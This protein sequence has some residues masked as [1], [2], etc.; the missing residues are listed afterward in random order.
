MYTVL[1]VLFWNRNQS[2][3][4]GTR[5]QRCS[6]TKGITRWWQDGAGVEEPGSG[7]PGPPASSEEAS[8]WESGLRGMDPGGFHN[9]PTA[10]WR[11][12]RLH[13]RQLHYHHCYVGELVQRILIYLFFCFMF[14]FCHIWSHSSLK[15]LLIQYIP[16]QLLNI[17]KK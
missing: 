8:G 14:T 7:S 6:R 2:L 12:H 11:L 1:T 3:F 5:R 15:I 9:R 17:L 10:V 16:C 4:S 13:N